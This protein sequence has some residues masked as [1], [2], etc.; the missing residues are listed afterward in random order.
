MNDI[1]Y[2]STL[3]RRIIVKRTILISILVALL[4]VGMLA[5]TV[6]AEEPHTHCVCGGSENRG[7]LEFGQP[8]AADDIREP[9]HGLPGGIDGL[10]AKGV[11]TGD[12]QV[13]HGHRSFLG[14]SIL[15]QSC[16]KNKKMHKRDFHFLRQDCI[17][18]LINSRQE[19]HLCLHST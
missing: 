8:I 7:D 11:K 18:I 4:M 16:C 1:L 3:I 14:L 5:V 17:I 10:A 6:S 12:E 9:A 2:S 13:F 19:E 15:S